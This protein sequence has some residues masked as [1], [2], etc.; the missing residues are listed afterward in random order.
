MDAARSG[1]GIACQR[2]HVADGIRRSVAGT[3]RFQRPS[4]VPVIRPS[5]AESIE[6]HSARRLSSPG[7]ALPLVERPALLHPA[8]SRVTDEALS[9]SPARIPQHGSCSRGDDVARRTTAG[10]KERPL[11]PAEVAENPQNLGGVSAQAAEMSSRRG[12]AAWGPKAARPAP[13]GWA[14]WPVPTAGSTGQTEGFHAIPA[15]DS[16]DTGRVRKAPERPQERVPP[17]EPRG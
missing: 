7:S 2:P 13:A 12:P 6:N 8:S 1:E 3:A 5:P 11:A 14:G 4:P 17:P 9:G 16:T 10:R 15:I